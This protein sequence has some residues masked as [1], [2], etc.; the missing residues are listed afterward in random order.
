MNKVTAVKIPP[1]L[2]GKHSSF[3]KAEGKFPLVITRSTP[4]HRPSHCKQLE[5]VGQTNSLINLHKVPE[6]HMTIKTEGPV[7]C[8]VNGNERAPP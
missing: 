7:V 5:K 6:T 1:N 4:S 3:L 8:G 2:K